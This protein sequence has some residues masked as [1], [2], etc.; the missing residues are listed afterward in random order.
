MDPKSVL[1]ALCLKKLCV[2]EPDHAEDTSAGCGR[3]EAVEALKSCG[4]PVVDLFL[5]LCRC[6]RSGKDDFDLVIRRCDDLIALAYQKLYA[7]MPVPSCWKEL[8]FR[9]SMLKFSALVM[10]DK[11][12]APSAMH[13]SVNDIMDEMVKT[14]DMALI[15]TGP[16]RSETIREAVVEALKLLQEFDAGA[17][18]DF[19]FQ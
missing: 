5:T 11:W 19:K 12:N 4:K 14:I 2:S 15:M 13:A 8:Y 16:P 7:C 3:Q 6:V 17:N 18:S 10:S 1:A 9:V